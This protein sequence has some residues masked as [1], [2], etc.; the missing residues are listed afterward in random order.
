MRL[1]RGAIAM[2][3]ETDQREAFNAGRFSIEVAENGSGSVALQYFGGETRPA[4]VPLENVAGKTRHMPD[5]FLEADEN[6][7]AAEGMEYL[8]RLLPR[9]FNPGKPFV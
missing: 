7:I 5:G 4:L 2:I 6:R 1:P 8:E 9:R 3:S